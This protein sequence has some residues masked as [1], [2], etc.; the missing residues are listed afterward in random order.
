M[1]TG[2]RRHAAEAVANELGLDEVRAGL[3]PED[4]VAAIQSLRAAGRKVGDGG[5]RR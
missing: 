4:K 1:L 3:S 2:D 5:R